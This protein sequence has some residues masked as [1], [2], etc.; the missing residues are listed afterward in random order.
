MEPL[1]HGDKNGVL[2]LA[3]LQ[4]KSQQRNFSIIG[5]LWLKQACQGAFHGRA[6]QQGLSDAMVG[7]TFVYIVP[8][9]NML[10]LLDTLRTSIHFI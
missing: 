1:A 9:V 6:F 2:A 3:E 7:S 5:Q 4:S 8:R 10:H